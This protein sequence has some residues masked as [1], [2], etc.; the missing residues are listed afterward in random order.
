MYTAQELA[1]GQNNDKLTTWQRQPQQ[2]AILG[3]LVEQVTILAEAMGETMTLAR[4]KIYAGDLVDINQTALE[5]AFQRA[6]RECHFFP[7]IAELRK[8][9]GTGEGNQEDA[10]ARR[11]WDV[12]MDFVRKYVGND[13]YGHYGPEH[14]WYTRWPILSDRILDTV[15]RIGGWKVLACITNENFPFVQKRFFDE[16]KAWTAVEKVDLNELIQEMPRLHLAAETMDSPESAGLCGQSKAKKHEHAKRTKPL[17]EGQL[18][19][20]RE[21]LREQAAKLIKARSR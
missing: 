2:S 1:T 9:A 8:F 20:R 21:M 16:Y 6:R 4:L 19:D 15:R 18:R 13:I 11:S 7:K 12:V 17:S 3:W 14:G 10:E 5:I